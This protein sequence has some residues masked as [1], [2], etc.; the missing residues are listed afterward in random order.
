MPIALLYHDVSPA[1]QDDASGFPGPGA[2]R[3]KL[4]PS[5][6]GNHLTALKQVATAPTLTRLDNGQSA[7]TGWLLTF[8]DGGASALE[9]IADQLEARGWRGWFFITTNFIGTSGFLSA[10]AIRDLDQRG[11]II[12]SHSCSH[13]RRMSCCSPVELR[14]E[15]TR[16]RC[17]LENILGAPVTSASVPGGFYSK[18]VAAAAEHAGLTTLFT[19][20][21]TVRDD[22][23]GRCRVYGRFT[24]YRGM[25]ADAAAALLR[26]PWPRWRQA[27]WWSTKKLA[28]QLA[29]ETYIRLRERFWRRAYAAS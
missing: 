9:P 28:K 4:T 27:C 18:S 21:P 19:S 26:S 29:G 20:E 1:G 6:F 7:D 24:V 13:P 5:E 8:D 23:V 10:D 25:T 11:H 16:S 2:A 17:V 3:Y 15:W 22:Q 14:N 12:G